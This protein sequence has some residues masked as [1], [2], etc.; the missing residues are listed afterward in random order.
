[1]FRAEANHR[2]NASSKFDGL[3]L[4]VWF[5]IAVLPWIAIYAFGHKLLG[6]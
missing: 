4:S 5:F 3:K 6:I 2:S 1:M